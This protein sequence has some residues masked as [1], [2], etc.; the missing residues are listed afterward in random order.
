MRKIDKVVTE[1]HI[2][3]ASN[4]LPTLFGV[5]GGLEAALNGPISKS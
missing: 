4:D 3:H 1:K 2:P 5:G